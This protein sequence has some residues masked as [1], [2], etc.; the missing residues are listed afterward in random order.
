MIWFCVDR[1]YYM[2][3]VQDDKTNCAEYIILMVVIIS[4]FKIIEFNFPII[5]YYILIKD[6]IHLLLILN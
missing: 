1:Y 3:N 4:K 2:D 6:Y 5:N